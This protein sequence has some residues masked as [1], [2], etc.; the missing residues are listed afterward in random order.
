VSARMLADYSTKETC[1]M[2]NAKAVGGTSI[3]NVQFGRPKR[4]ARAVATTKNRWGIDRGVKPHG[5]H[6]EGD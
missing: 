2:S 4:P 1:C 5:P 6:V 3:V